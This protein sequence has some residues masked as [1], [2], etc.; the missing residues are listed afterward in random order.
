MHAMKKFIGFGIAAA[1]AL[2]IVPQA[3]AAIT[4]PTTGSDT[5]TAAIEMDM[6]GYAIITAMPD[7]VISLAPSQS[8]YVTGNA[9]S[10]GANGMSLSVRTNDV[11]GAILK[12]SS[13]VDAG[14][15]LQNGDVTLL[16]SVTGANPG[17]VIESL[18]LV[19]DASQQQ[20]WSVGTAQTA[21]EVGSTLTIGAKVDNLWR[22]TG[23]TGTGGG[24]TIDHDKALTFT[25][26]PQ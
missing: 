3:N 8:E 10:S 21:D 13:A 7:S 24:T 26:A 11:N 6:A 18:P 20:I 2:S 15:S 19:N 4:N 1:V 17:T 23:G 22:Y 9:T 25:I 14:D 12:V 5:G 16:S